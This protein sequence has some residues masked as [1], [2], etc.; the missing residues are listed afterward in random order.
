[1]KNSLNFMSTCL[2]VVDTRRVFMSGGHYGHENGYRY[3]FV[4]NKV[5]NVA[6]VIKGMKTLQEEQT[7]EKQW[8]CGGTN[9]K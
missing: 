6:V 3:Q 7:A 2:K 5:T 1:M 9:P 4:A 8:A